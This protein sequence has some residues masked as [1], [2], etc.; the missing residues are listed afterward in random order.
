[1]VSEFIDAEGTSSPPAAT[2]S[3]SSPAQSD[4][5]ED[6]NKKRRYSLLQKDDTSSASTSLGT[7]TATTTTSKEMRRSS[8]DTYY[9]YDDYLIDDDTVKVEMNLEEDSTDK[10]PAP[11]VGGRGR[12]M[13]QGDSHVWTDE[14]TDALI[15]A[16]SQ[17]E[18]LFQKQH[19]LF[20]VTEAKDRAVEW[21]R[22]YLLEHGHNATTNQI[23]SKFQSLRTYFCSQRNK[24]LN[25]RRQGAGDNVESKWRFY[26]DLMFLDQNMKPREKVANK[27]HQQMVRD[28]AHENESREGADNFSGDGNGHENYSE[29]SMVVVGTPH[30]GY[31][32]SR[33]HDHITNGRSLQSTP[34][35]MAPTSQAV[36]RVAENSRQHEDLIFGELVG[37]MMT[38]IP[39]SQGKDYLKLEIQ[40][41]IV[42]HKYS[43]SQG[44][45]QS[46][47][48]D[49]TNNT[50]EGATDNGS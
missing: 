36:S 23:T 21:I 31:V 38:H 42:K 9:N 32:T 7:P 11:R 39:A 26:K 44:T 1:M 35:M 20:Y 15:Y 34:K 12:P 22:Q 3:T 30:H 5:N 27:I 41:L 19:P 6:T 50:Q 25:L 40:Q 10:P 14:A 46:Q 37:N 49:V 17:K 28:I 47:P 16:W 29:N 48:G 4:L 2:S 18:E 24:L 8:Y 45:S 33:I 13:K 43:T